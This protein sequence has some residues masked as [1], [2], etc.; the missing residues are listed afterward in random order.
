MDPETFLMLLLLFL[1]DLIHQHHFHEQELQAADSADFLNLFFYQCV[2]SSFMA[3]AQRRRR[4]AICLRER[5]G[6]HWGEF[7][8]VCFCPLLKATRVGR[9]GP[10]FVARQ[11]PLVAAG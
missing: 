10:V 1:S 6:S 3:E 11:L 9:P 2:I 4:G 8:T 5:R 7:C